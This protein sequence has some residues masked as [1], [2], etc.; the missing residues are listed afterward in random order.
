MPAHVCVRACVRACVLVCLCS[1]L[2]ACLQ[3]KSSVKELRLK[4]RETEQAASVLEDQLCSLKQ[5]SDKLR[6]QLQAKVISSSS[7]R[8]TRAHPFNGPL[9]GTTWVGRYHSVHQAAKLVA[10][11]LSVAG[12]TAGLAESNGSLP[13]GL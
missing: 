10:A 1:C 13:P 9:S 12:V 2:C 5:S 7:C 11:L 8:H 3:L 6:D 4:Q